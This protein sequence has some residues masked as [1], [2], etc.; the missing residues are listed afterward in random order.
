M[1]LGF[2]LFYFSIIHIIERGACKELYLMGLY[3]VMGSWS[4]P[5]GPMAADLALE[6]INA[7]PDILQGYNLNV[8]WRD[9]RCLDRIAVQSFIDALNDSSRTY[10]GVFGPGCSVAAVAIANISPLYGLITLTYGAA[11]PSL[12]DKIRYPYF[13]RG[14]VSDTNIAAG[15]INFIKEHGWKRVAIVNQQEE[16]FVY[17][18]FVIQQALRRLD[19]S[20]RSET[21]DPRSSEVDQQISSVIALI[22]DEGYR[23]V[24]G[25]MYETAAIQFACQLY[26]TRP[27]PYITWLFIGWYTN[28]WDEV[29]YNVTNGSCTTENIREVLNGAIGIISFSRF[30][31]ILQSNATTIAGYTPQQLY[32]IYRERAISDNIDFEAERDVID[33]YLYD[34]LWTYALGLNQTIAQGF[35]PSQFT[36]KESPMTQALYQNSFS[37]NFSGWTG[38]VS[39]FGRERIANRV[40]VS[41]FVNGN[42]QYRGYYENFPPNPEEFANTEGVIANIGKFQIWNED[43]ASD[44]IEDY[45]THIGIFATT[46]ASAILVG[47]YITSLIIIILV[48]VKKNLPPATKSEPFLNIFILTGNYFSLLLGV[49]FTTDGKFFVT[50][51]P[52]APISITYCHSQIW[53]MTIVNSIVFGGVL[54]KAAKYYIIVVKNKFKYTDWVQARYLLILP[55]SLILLNTI[56]V[57]IWAF[58]SPLTYNPS[59]SPSGLSDPPFYQT[60]TCGGHSIGFAVPLAILNVGPILIGTFLAYHLRKV[61]NKSQRYSSVIVWTMYTMLAF[62]V[63]LFIVITFVNDANIRVGLAALLTI[64]QAITTATIIA[65]PVV[66]YLIKDPNGTTFFKNVNQEDFP[67]DSEMLKLRIEALER[68]LQVYKDKEFEQSSGLKRVLYR[69]KKATVYDNQSFDMGDEGKGKGKSSKTFGGEAGEKNEKRSK[70]NAF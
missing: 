69:I 52:N 42:I 7:H 60:Y 24:I 65:M 35:D 51:V 36:Y 21:F 66:Y 43:L 47:I 45:F 53:L 6:H 38:Q 10:L 22:K 62:T 27:I 14:I 8:D 48:G 54:A 61:V 67:E 57:V 12:E 26:K 49:V 40:L 39:Y 9:S 15:R 31:D 30:E 11:S 13:I 37:Q 18:S 55:F 68:D 32:D 28:G 63:A 58:V 17:N 23:I 5:L 25:N 46:L 44:G 50:L 29:A 70:T 41:E 3:P 16:I 56:I 2:F 33:A 4:L 59:V 19:V 20:Y 34:S 64:L 1:K